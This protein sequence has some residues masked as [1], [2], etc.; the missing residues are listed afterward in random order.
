[1]QFDCECGATSYEDPP[2]CPDCGKQMKHAA[3]RLEVLERE[4]AEFFERWHVERRKREALRMALKIAHENLEDTAH[5][6]ETGVGKEKILRSLA[7]K[8]RH[9]A[10]ALNVSRSR[11]T[12]EPHNVK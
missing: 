1:M 9:A 3:A 2:E 6:V 5:L 4:H 10:D 12:T 8:M 11:T 7:I